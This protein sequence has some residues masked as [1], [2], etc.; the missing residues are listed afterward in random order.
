KLEDS[1]HQWL[2]LPMRE[3]T[4]VLLEDRGWQAGLW[5]SSW[6]TSLPPDQLRYFHHDGM[7]RRTWLLL[8]ED[9]SEAT[10]DDDDEFPTYEEQENTPEIAKHLV[11][12]W[13]NPPKDIAA[14]AGITLRQLRWLTT[15][16]ASLDGSARYDLTRLLGIE[17]DERMGGYTPAGPY[18]L[19]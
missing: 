3:P 1:I 7:S 9:P 5:L 15:E 17:Y 11:A 12:C 8:G 19:I 2:D 16:R 4:S 6:E 14:A 13:P 10:H 18:V